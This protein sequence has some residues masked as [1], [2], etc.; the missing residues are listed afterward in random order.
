MSVSYAEGRN[1]I[2]DGDIVFVS[3]KETLTARVVQFFTQSPYSHC[4]F[5]FW[6]NIAGQRRLMMVEA[7]GSAKRR[8]VNMSNYR[9][10]EL[11]I[12]R[13]KHKWTELAPKALD[14]LGLIKY[15]WMDAVYVGICESALKHLN[16]KLPHKDFP[17]EICSEFCARVMGMEQ[18]HLSPQVLWEQLEKRDYKIRVIIR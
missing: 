13:T 11:D 14:R 2:K 17:G 12:V 18:T 3:N 4:G 9:E 7:Q 5:A 10:N 16:I 6:V 15:G 8:I 1:K